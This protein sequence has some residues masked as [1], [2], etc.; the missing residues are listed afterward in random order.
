MVKKVLMVSMRLKWGLCQFHQ[1]LSEPQAE[2][3]RKRGREPPHVKPDVQ[4]PVWGMLRDGDPDS[5][6]M[7]THLCL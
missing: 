7:S 1:F 6:G 2:S 3:S 5:A 4:S